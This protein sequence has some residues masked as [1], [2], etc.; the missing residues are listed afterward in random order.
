VKSLDYGIVSTGIYSSICQE[1]GIYKTKRT[2]LAYTAVS[3]AKKNFLIIVNSLI[4]FSIFL[5]LFTLFIVT[6]TDKEST[7]QLFNLMI[8][9]IRAFDVE[10]INGNRFSLSTI[11]FTLAIGGT[12]SFQQQIII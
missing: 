6:L 7:I 3:L 9:G 2:S 8:S 11:F 12:V 1:L 5:A 4:L 10:S